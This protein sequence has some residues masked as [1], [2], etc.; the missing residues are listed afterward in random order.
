[1]TGA[2]HYSVLL[3][4]SVAAVLDSDLLSRKSHAAS[5]IYI[6]GTYGRGGHSRAILAHLTAA[7]RVLAIDKDPEAIVSAN[8][9]A[10]ADSRFRI[11]HGSFSEMSTALARSTWGEQVDGIL[12][13]LGVSSPQLDNAERG[14]SFLQDGPLDMRMNTGQALSAADWIN[15]ADGQ[16]IA[17]VLW[18]F[19]EERFSRRIARAIVEERK[20][21]PI[22]GTG[23]LAEIVKRANPRWEKDKHPA[24][25]AFQAIRI[26]I[27]QELDDLQVALES[28]VDI[29][30]PGGRLVVIS[31]HSLEDRIVKRFFKHAAKGPVLPKEVMITSEMWQPKLKTVGKAV[32]A[33]GVEMSHNI[34]SRSAVMRVAEK[35][36]SDF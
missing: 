18:E 36:D 24:T 14:F 30:K 19:G 1:M 5:G 7:G 23:R 35:I 33:G 29:L 11:H 31:F 16:E 34:R 20:A 3:Q 4:E 10:A 6:D 17:R 26:F 13:D 15:S 8:E 25:R 12:L 21:Q 9:L 32:K 2:E 27:N 28:A 22:T